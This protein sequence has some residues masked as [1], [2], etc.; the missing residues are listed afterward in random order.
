MPKFYIE[1]GQIK[2]II[3]AKNPLRAC[4]RALEYLENNKSSIIEFE[5]SFFVSEKGFLSDREVMQ[6]TIPEE[7]VI[8]T[9]EVMKEYLNG[10][11]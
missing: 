11:H 3:Q 7:T 2:V 10:R 6:I 8:G 9:E 1:S 5:D 4:V